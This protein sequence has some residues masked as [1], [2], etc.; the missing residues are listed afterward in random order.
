MPRREEQRAIAYSTRIRA[1]GRIG[2]SLHKSSH[3]SAV[4]L[5]A[6]SFAKSS[7]RRARGEK[8]VAAPAGFV[9]K[10]HPPPCRSGK[11]KRTHDKLCRFR[12][13]A[14]TL[15]L[16]SDIKPAVYSS[17]TGQHLEMRLADSGEQARARGDAVVLCVDS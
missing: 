9:T 6:A 12:G 4:G 1:L 8:M 14:Y 10:S 7:H 15:L 16:T 3:K 2:G 17:D 5:K 11:K 13:A